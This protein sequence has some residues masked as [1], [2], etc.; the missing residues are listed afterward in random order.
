MTIIEFLYFDEN[1]FTFQYSDASHI[2]VP[3]INE[4]IKFSESHHKYHNKWFTVVSVDHEIEVG[5]KH[6]TKI[7]LR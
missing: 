6:V 4:R 7:L 1:V 3:K 2:I 5:V